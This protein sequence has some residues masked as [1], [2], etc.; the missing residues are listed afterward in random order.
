MQPINAK[1]TKNKYILLLLTIFLMIT[2]VACKTQKVSQS[3]QSTPIDIYLPDTSALPTFPAE[4][5]YVLG[6]QWENNSNLQ[7][8][9]TIAEYIEKELIRLYPEKAYKGY[10]RNLCTKVDT[11]LKDSYQTPTLFVPKRNEINLTSSRTKSF[12]LYR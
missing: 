6:A 9:S 5:I 1:M 4:V 7:Q 10:I 12:D 11:L 8:E 2:M 3:M